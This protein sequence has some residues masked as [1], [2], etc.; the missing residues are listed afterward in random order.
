MTGRILW[1]NV[2]LRVKA[3][4]EAR[5][6]PRPGETAI[7][8]AARGERWYFRRTL[9]GW[10]HIST[11]RQ[12]SNDSIAVDLDDEQRAQALAQV[13]RMEQKM[14]EWSAASAQRP[15]PRVQSAPV[16]P[17]VR[18]SL[19][20]DVYT[21]TCRPDSRWEVC[22]DR[23]GRELETENMRRFAECATDL[24]FEAPTWWI[25]VSV[26]EV[27]SSARELTIVGELLDSRYAP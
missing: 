24:E 15:A 16:Q 2:P 7:V 25:K 13:E 23:R 11:D 10:N 20:D 27:R 21:I 4:L 9:Y 6:R 14:R 26:L 5:T 8:D 17:Y 22:V 18:I 19:V 1:E 12:S 3:E